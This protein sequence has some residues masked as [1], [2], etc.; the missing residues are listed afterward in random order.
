ML[1]LLQLKDARQVMW[2]NFSSQMQLNPI[3]SHPSNASVVWTNGEQCRC[4]K[5][6]YAWK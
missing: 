2:A 6:K 3:G 5:H 1:N 4:T